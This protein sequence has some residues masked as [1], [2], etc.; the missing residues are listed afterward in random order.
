MVA[1]ISS[2]GFIET[3][4]LQLIMTEY[5]SITHCNTLKGDSLTVMI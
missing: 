2:V 1:L 5:L 4:I 3:Y